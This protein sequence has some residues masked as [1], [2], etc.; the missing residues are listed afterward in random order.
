M[1]GELDDLVKDVKKYSE[2]RE[3]GELL[4]QSLLAKLQTA[5]DHLQDGRERAAA[6]RLEAF[7]DQIEEQRGK[8]ISHTAAGDL[9]PRAEAL[10][11]RLGGGDGEDPGR[12]S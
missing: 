4:A 9:I 10:I 12:D 5:R 3:I 7:V 11:G 1:L 2:D 8:R 6:N